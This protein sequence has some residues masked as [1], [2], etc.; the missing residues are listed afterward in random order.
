MGSAQFPASPGNQ[1]NPHPPPTSARRDLVPGFGGPDVREQPRGGYR[2][3][4]EKPTERP[5]ARRIRP[6]GRVTT[7]RGGPDVTPAKSTRGSTLWGAAERR[8][9][10]PRLPAT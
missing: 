4:H 6:R 3:T 1:R 8:P 9:S 7:G 5:D 10:R 2:W